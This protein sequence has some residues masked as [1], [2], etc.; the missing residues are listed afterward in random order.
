MADLICREIEA[1]EE[2][3][4]CYS[5][6]LIEGGQCKASISNLVNM[7]T[8]TYWKINNKIEGVKGRVKT[9]YATMNYT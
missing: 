1:D 6:D 3:S 9:W 8:R 5:E 7:A 2:G 4:D